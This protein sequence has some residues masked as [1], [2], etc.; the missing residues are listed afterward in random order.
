DDGTPFPATIDEIDDLSGVPG[1][2]KPGRL[3]YLADLEHESEA[4]YTFTSNSRGGIRAVDDLAA[5]VIRMG[6]RKPLAFPVI[7]LD[8]TSYDHRSY[9][10]V[11]R[12]VFPVRGWE[13]ESG[14]PYPEKRNEEPRKLAPNGGRTPVNDLD[15]DIPF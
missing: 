14:E 2:W 12:P 10:R 7:R 13:T 8:A 1:T 5:K 3:L 9:G 6:R 15:D 11:D 4:E